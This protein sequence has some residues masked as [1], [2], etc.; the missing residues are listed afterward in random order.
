MLVGYYG[1]LSSGRDCTRD[2]F[3]VTHVYFSGYLNIFIPQVINLCF[4]R[5]FVL[6]VEAI[7]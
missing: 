6:R 7:A 3:G 2:N 4:I 5:I 1:R